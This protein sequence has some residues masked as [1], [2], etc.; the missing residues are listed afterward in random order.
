MVLH[1]LHLQE[2]R[3]DESCFNYRVALHP[4][5]D[6]NAPPLRMIYEFCCDVDSWLCQDDEHVIAVH[7]KAGKGRTG[8]MICCYMLHTAIVNT[9]SEA[10]T[11]YGRIRTFNGNGVTIPSQ[12]RYINYYEQCLKYGFPLQDRAVELNNVKM[13]GSIHVTG[14]IWVVIKSSGNVVFCS[15]DVLGYLD[16]SNA[17][18]V[19]ELNNF[20]TCLQGDFKILVFYYNDNHQYH[21]KKR[22]KLFHASINTNYLSTDK[23]NVPM[24]ILTK[25]ELDEAHKDKKHKIFDK[26]F[27]LELRFNIKKEAICSPAQRNIGSFGVLNSA[28]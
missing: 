5:K 8:T 27:R 13:V 11:Y 26:D 7:C 1:S 17:G 12:I 21:K 4:F 18:S 22:C 14:W 6:H 25:F 28:Q 20:S 16:N 3:Y 10:I 23:N 9:A 15:K 2:R 24:L 19:L